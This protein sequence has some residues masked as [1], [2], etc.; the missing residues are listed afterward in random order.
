[1]DY[2]IR[3]VVVMEFG[4]VPAAVVPVGVK[5]PVVALIVKIETSL[6]PALAA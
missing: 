6:E 5:A 3:P 2:W 4:A 1:M